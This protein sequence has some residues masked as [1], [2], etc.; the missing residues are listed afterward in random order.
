MAISPNVPVEQ[1][2]KQTIRAVTGGG[3]N[4]Y[5]TNPLVASLVNATDVGNLNLQ[6]YTL[7]VSGSASTTFT[8]SGSQ[9][10]AT[11]L[12]ANTTVSGF[13]GTLAPL[14]A[15]SGI[16]LTVWNKNAD[17][18]G[19][20]ATNGFGL[21]SLTFLLSAAP[22]VTLSDL[23]ITSGNS[24]VLPAQILDVDITT[25]NETLSY[26]NY[27]ATPNAV[28]TWVD[29]A[30]VHAYPIYGF[31]NTTQDTSKTQQYQVRQIQTGEGPDG[32]LHTEIY[33]GYY[34]A[35]QSNLNQTHQKNTKQQQ[36]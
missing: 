3:A 18:L 27:Y 22:G 20:Q 16:A 33:A 15:P 34:A 8:I 17:Y 28:P 1:Q 9:F 11:G 5:W 12:T 4:A 35:Y 23:T 30:T 36:C 14:L 26:P 19:N 24:S 21:G 10:V 7:I 31:G 25:A 32:G 6:A 2:T 13:V 29:D